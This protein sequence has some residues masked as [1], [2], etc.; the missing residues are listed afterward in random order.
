MTVEGK[1][2]AAVAPAGIP[3]IDNLAQ[4]VSLLGSWGLSVSVG[5]HV[6]DRFRYLAG[7]RQHRTGDL[8][9]ALS[10]PAI[11]IVWIARAGYGC[12]H[13]LSQ[14]P[15]TVPCEKTVIGF[16]DATALFYALREIPGIRVIH[17]PT[18]N[19]LATKVDDVSRR[20]V[21]D[22]LAGVTPAPLQLERLHGPADAIKGPLVG[23]NLTVL[24]ST[25]GSRWQPYFRDS[26]VV[27]EDVTELAYRIDRSIMTLRH[28][29]ILDG[30]RA[31]VLGEFVRCPLP[32]GADYSLADVLLDVLAPLGVPIYRGLAVGHGERNLSWVVGRPAEIR[33]S[34]LLR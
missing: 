16:S 8:L 25:A 22:T 3:D 12:A 30:A 32:A 14:L 6:A 29:G 4:A 9:A 1:R 2:V 13:V 11:D 21:F 19:G 28:A 34:V 31:I 10:D 17:G 7:S 15:T 20:S 23:G 24:A 18:L 27:L 26:I 5:A 33:D